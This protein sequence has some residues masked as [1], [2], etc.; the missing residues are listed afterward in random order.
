MTMSEKPR[1]F[2]ID[3]VAESDAE[4]AMRTSDGLE[5]TQ[6]PDP[7][8]RPAAAAD[9][10]ASAKR[11]WFGW[12]SLFAAAVSGLLVMAIA[13]SLQNYVVDLLRT[14]PPLGYLALALAGL[15]AL[16]LLGF[17]LREARGV[18]RAARIERL[19]RQVAQARH[20]DDLSAGRAATRALVAL[21]ASRAASARGRA[22]L[23]AI[24]GDLIDAR[25]RLA[26]AERELMTDLDALARAAT[27]AAA[28]RVA[29]ATTISPRALV[30]IL[31]VLA[32]SVALVRRV[33]EIYGGRPGL[34]GFA[35]VAR[36]VLIHIAVT[37]G[38]AIGD[39]LAQ[40]ILGAGLAARLSARLGEGV[41]NGMLTARVGLSAIAVCRPMAF[42]ALPAPSLSD[43]ASGLLSGAARNSV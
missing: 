19:A 41:V 30:D 16:G 1:A 2:R 20:S 10:Q 33:S 29:L 42:D 22:R 25:A 14:N 35:R 21:Y 32:A 27:T 11:P 3:P 15:A 36:Q 26:I 17:L 34:V 31:F 24:D 12:L 38:V 37:G 28:S 4:R 40:Q 43:V 23:E 8:E 39:G 6:T 5:L 18:F 9:I 13:T 7:F